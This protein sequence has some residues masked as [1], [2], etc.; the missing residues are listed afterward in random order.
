MEHLNVCQ[1]SHYLICP[2]LPRV[3]FLI[4][5]VVV[6]HHLWVRVQRCEV[7]STHQIAQIFLDLQPLGLDFIN[8]HRSF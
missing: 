6:L 3:E 1:H 8:A 5:P 4:L 2:L 7:T